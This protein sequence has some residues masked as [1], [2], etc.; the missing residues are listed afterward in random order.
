VVP[1]VGQDPCSKQMAA[2]AFALAVGG[3]SLAQKVKHRQKM[4]LYCG[5]RYNTLR[6]SPPDA[7]HILAVIEFNVPHAKNGGTDKG[8]DGHRIDS[9]PI[10]NGVIKAGG[11]CDIIKYCCNR[12]DDFAALLA[13]YDA[14][15]VRINPGQLSQGTPP[16]TQD[17]FDALITEQSSKGKVV[18]PLP[19]VQTKMGAKSALVKIAGL[20]IG[21]VDTFAY[22]TK[23]QLVSGF[24][25]T[26]AFQPRVLKQ[27]R[28]SAGEGIW[29]CWLHDKTYCS[30][31]GDA[32]LD[33]TDMLKL[34][35]MTDNHVE[36]HTVGE[37]LK[38]CVDGPDAPGAGKWKSVSQG[39]YLEGGAALGGQLVA[40]RLCPRIT[41]GEVRVLMV[42]N[43]PQMVIVKKPIGGGSSAVGG[44][45][46]YTYYLPDDEK[47]AFLCDVVKASLPQ[48]MSVLNLKGEPVPLFWTA[49]L[50]PK[51]AEDGTPGKTE[52]VVGELNCSCVGVSKFQAVCG[53]DQT[54]ADV[55]DEDYFDAVQ[56]TDLIGVKAIEV[57]DALVV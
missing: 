3:A 51:D 36:Y 20:P 22:Y 55:P 30:K 54:L 6:P 40:Q 11:A 38:F 49:D 18:W 26:M 46:A 53:G 23:D 2:F 24:K 17:K 35:D 42:G 34:M 57:L 28:G 5:E 1:D 19:S 32:S 25:Q 29:L 48:L 41:E 13:G 33:D 31:F 39:K 9:I 12:H 45:A 8:P 44:N 27:N 7:K 15:I 47:Y 43:V 21:L 16:G 52:Y 4:P 56:L 14:F 10:A 50:I 37:F